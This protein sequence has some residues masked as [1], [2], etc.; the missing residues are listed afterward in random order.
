VCLLIV[1]GSRHGRWCCCPSHSSGILAETASCHLLNTVCSCLI[2][3]SYYKQMP[4]LLLTKLS[5]M[6]LMFTPMCMFILNGHC[7]W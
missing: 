4:Q 2:N 7:T 1:V 3:F 6:I 5:V